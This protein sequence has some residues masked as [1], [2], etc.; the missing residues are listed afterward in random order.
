MGYTIENMGNALI[1]LTTSILGDN[2]YDVGSIA[3]PF[4]MRGSCMYLWKKDG[5]S[6]E[7]DTGSLQSW[8][9]CTLASI[10][11]PGI[12][13]D[14]EI[15]RQV[16]ALKEA[17]ATEGQG[18]L[19]KISNDS[20]LVLQYNAPGTLPW[21]RK[22]QVAFIVERT[23]EAAVDPTS[24][25]AKNKAGTANAPNESSGDTTTNKAKDSQNGDNDLESGHIGG[26]TWVATEAQ[27]DFFQL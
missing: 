14:G 2:N 3:A 22:N 16:N 4:I 12:C 24:I 7:P 8:L 1:Q 15:K 20:P 25:L 6:S 23:G 17:L 9:A 26:S 5:N 10:E 21:R 11:F 27:K 19:W 13:T 18:S